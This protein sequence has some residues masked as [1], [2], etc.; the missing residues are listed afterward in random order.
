MGLCFEIRDLLSLFFSPSL[1]TGLR[2]LFKK[3]WV[4]YWY[5]GMPA[6]YLVLALLLLSLGVRGFWLGFV[7]LPSHLSLGIVVSSLF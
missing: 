6:D 1:D 5:L 7:I 4:L 3:S 2:F